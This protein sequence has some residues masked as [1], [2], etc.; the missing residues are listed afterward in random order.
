MVSRPTPSPVTL[1]GGG[2]SEGS[3]N[4]IEGV[5]A[6]PTLVTVHEG[7][8]EPQALRASPLAP[9][10]SSGTDAVRSRGR[11]MSRGRR[12]LAV[13]G[14]QLQPGSPNASVIKKAKASRFMGRLFK[15]HPFVVDEDGHVTKAVAFDRFAR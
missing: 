11:A 2:L 3:G 12:M 10:R 15:L 5:P 9:R 13:A 14:P 6:G 4:G 8:S 1:S 7:S